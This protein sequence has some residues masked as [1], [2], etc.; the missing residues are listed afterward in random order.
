MM[1]VKEHLA[2]HDRQIKAIRDLLHEGM[3]MMV[4]TRKDL[5]QMGRRMDQLTRN[6]ELLVQGRSDGHGKRR[7]N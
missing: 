2:L 4:E 1:A 5:R 7:I 6:V 3:K